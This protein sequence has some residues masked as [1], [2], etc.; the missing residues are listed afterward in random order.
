LLNDQGPKRSNQAK[1]IWKLPYHS[2]DP[3]LYAT[4][5][6]VCFGHV[7]D[8]LYSA[9]FDKTVKVWDLAESG[10]ATCVETLR[11]KSNVELRALSHQSSNI[12]ATCQRTLEASIPIYDLLDSM[13]WVAPK[14]TLQSP[15]AWKGKVYPSSLLL[16][17]I[18]GTSYLVPS[19]RRH[20]SRPMDP[21]VRKL[22]RQYCYGEGLQNCTRHSIEMYCSYTR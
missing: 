9:S 8:R 17:T 3:E 22:G 18:R 6:Q 2:V 10:H 19:K 13:P 5:S 16:G 21:I 4:I 7:S 20:S 11:H 1:T 12:L 14:T 15:R